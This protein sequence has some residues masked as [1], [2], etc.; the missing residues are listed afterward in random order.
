MR[1]GQAVRPARS[2]MRLHLGALGPEGDYGQ[3]PACDKQ[4]PGRLHAFG[5]DCSRQ[6][7][8]FL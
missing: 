1:L 6:S 8:N 2:D 4:V 7:G 5:P 3:V